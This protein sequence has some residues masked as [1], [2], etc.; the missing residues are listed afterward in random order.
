MND[1]LFT[2]TTYFNKHK[3]GVNSERTIFQ[4]DYVKMVMDSSC[5]HFSRW[6]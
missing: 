6:L 1:A 5:R 2:A 4:D 3:Y